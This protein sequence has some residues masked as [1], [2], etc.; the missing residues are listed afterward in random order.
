MKYIYRRNILI[1]WDKFQTSSDGAS[2]SLSKSVE[3]SAP[4]KDKSNSSLV[5]SHH[6]LKIKLKKV[7]IF[8]SKKELKLV[9]LDHKLE[10]M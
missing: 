6:V 4:N 1:S 10:W 5:K 8:L 2:T 7:N 9:G 3:E